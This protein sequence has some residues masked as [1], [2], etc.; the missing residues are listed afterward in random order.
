ME[1]NIK[2]VQALSVT[3]LGQFTV[4]NADQVTSAAPA[5][6]KDGVLERMRQGITQEEAIKRM[7]STPFFEKNWVAA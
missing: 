7:Q 2:T 3:N 5:W 1:Q 4:L 6:F